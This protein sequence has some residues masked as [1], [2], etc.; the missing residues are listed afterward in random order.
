MKPTSAPLLRQTTLAA[1]LLTLP[2]TLSG[3]SKS[4]P[5]PAPAPVEEL[6]APD[7]YPD[8]LAQIQQIPIEN[9]PSTALRLHH[10]SMPTFKD[11]TGKV[12]GMRSMTMEFPLADGLS[13]AGLRIDDKV[14]FTFEVVWND[15]IPSWAVT[16]IEKIDP[17][18]E[19]DF[20]AP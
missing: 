18:T 2:I 11:S 5:A 10:Q 14:R 17:D 13:L 8:L 19:I 6:S 16:K 3:C 9:D 7:I 1:L 12:I 4:D 15:S 20:A